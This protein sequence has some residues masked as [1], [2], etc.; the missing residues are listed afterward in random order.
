MR[1]P[2]RE[3]TA[4]AGGFVMPMPSWLSAAISVPTLVSGVIGGIFGGAVQQYFAVELE[5][6]RTLL[7]LRKAAYTKFFEGQA[8]LRESREQ[9]ENKALRQ[10]SDEM[11]KLARF[12][13]AVYGSKPTVDALWT[14]YQR[15]DI[16]GSEA[17]NDCGTPRQR[18]QEDAAIYQG[19]RS[20][21][22]TRWPF[23]NAVDDDKLVFLIH[24]CVM[25]K[26]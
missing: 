17:K 3:T 24:G 1:E 18:W 23:S 5:Q 12:E 21:L 16:E 9:P 13:I 22:Q 7:D 15:S 4:A 26:K 11:I 6:Q 20:E 8:K 25:P 2:A 10:Q 19:M 14:Y